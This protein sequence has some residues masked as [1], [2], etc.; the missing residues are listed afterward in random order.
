MIRANITIQKEDKYKMKK[1]FGLMVALIL[2]LS[3]CACGGQPVAEQ[4]GESE[5]AVKTESKEEK[6]E[7][8]IGDSA[9]NPESSLDT[10]SVE[11]VPDYSQK[12]C[13]LSFPEI[14]KDVDTF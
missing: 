3:I 14:T 9:E 11:D 2:V 13:W 6:K 7:D 5:T 10:K 1:L 4:K 12:D 8:S